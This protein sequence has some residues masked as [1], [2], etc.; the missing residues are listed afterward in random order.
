MVR[1]EWER[2]PEVA[3]TPHSAISLSGAIATRIHLPPSLRA[4]ARATAYAVNIAI[5]TK[6][7]GLGLTS[8]ECWLLVSP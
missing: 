1:S 4:A 5:S 3:K 2:S 6:D 8:Q 7:R